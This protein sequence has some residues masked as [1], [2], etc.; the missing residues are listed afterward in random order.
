MRPI[1]LVIS[2]LLLAAL[3]F[4]VMPSFTA[5]SLQD[6]GSTDLSNVD[7]ISIAGAGIVTIGIGSPA[8]LTI[9]GPDSAMDALNIVVTNDELEI[10]PAQDDPA[11]PTAN[12]ELRFDIIVERI[13]DIRLRGSVQLEGAGIETQEMDVE[14]EGSSTATLT[15]LSL[16]ELDVRLEGASLMTVSGAT[17]ELDV[18]AHESSTFDGSA[19]VANSADIDAYDASLVIVNA[20]G[21]LD[22]EARSAAVVEYVGTPG[23]TDFEMSDAGTIRQFTGAVPAAPAASP[24]ASPGASPAATTGNTEVTM[25]GRAFTPATIEISAGDEVTW[26]NNDDSSHTVSSLGG[27][28]DSGTLDEGMSFS[29]TFDTAGSYDYVCAF[30]SEMQG[31]VV[32]S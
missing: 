29:F 23:S 19:L 8:S 31:T 5:S 20:T 25:A 2:G 6:S 11:S 12:D 18:E 7:S 27:P 22:V 30:H 17:S 13:E 4:A 10:E 28:F 26:V 1:P 24:V 3:T 14:L 32:V 9:S 16:D 21:N 15:E